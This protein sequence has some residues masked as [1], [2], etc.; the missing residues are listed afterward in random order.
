MKPNNEVLCA[1]SEPLD[2][3]DEVIS[4]LVWCA[5]ELLDW[6]KCKD[7]SP[8]ASTPLQAALD[9]LFTAVGQNEKLTRLLETLPQAL[10]DGLL[11]Q[12]AFTRLFETSPQPIAR[13]PFSAEDGRPALTPRELEV[14][15]EMAKGRFEKEIS[16]LD[17][18]ALAKATSSLWI[19]TPI[20]MCSP[21]AASSNSP[22][23]EDMS[24]LSRAAG[25]SAHGSILLVTLPLLV[26]ADCWS[27]AVLIP[28]LCWS[29]RR[30]AGL[31]A[32]LPLSS[33]KG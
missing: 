16:E 33:P 11:L 15:R 20:R 13:V 1:Q 17:V 18:T 10:G 26:M 28:T 29:L 32:A 19:A 5:A 4:A 2:L 24:V 6:T 3:H 22:P 7:T 9:N 31:S 30:A 21:G 14:L 23:M 25:I 8:D 27:P 12:V